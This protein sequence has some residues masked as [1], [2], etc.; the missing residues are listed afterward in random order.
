MKGDSFSEAPFY[1]II[2]GQRGAEMLWRQ[3]FLTG[4]P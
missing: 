4:E 3:A 2:S 1:F